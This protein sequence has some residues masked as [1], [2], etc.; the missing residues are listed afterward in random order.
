MYFRWDVVAMTI[1]LAVVFAFEMLGV[2]GARYITI[3]AIV[4]TVLPLWLRAMILG[5]MVYHFMSK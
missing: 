3:T 1:A 4:R 5:W 2:F